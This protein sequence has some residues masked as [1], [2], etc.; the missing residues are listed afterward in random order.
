MN[1]FLPSL[2]NVERSK[3]WYS[4]LGG[5]IATAP[6]LSVSPLPGTALTWIGRV[7]ALLMEMGNISLATDFKFA[8]D[9][10]TGTSL[11]SPA[12]QSEKMRTA[13][14]LALGVAERLA[15]VL[16]RG[17]YIPVGSA[18]DALIAISGVLGKAS[19]DV[20]IIDP[21][22]SQVVLNDFALSLGEGVKL[23]LLS[24]HK[25]TAPDLEPALRA[26]RQQRTTRPTE[27]RIAKQEALHDRIIVLDG[28][29]WSLSQSFNALAKRSPATLQPF[30]PEL[31]SLKT[32]YY[33]DLWT[34]ATPL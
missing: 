6:D 20:F 26:W 1:L 4:E 27:V 30:E 8:F 15:P 7:H 11:D 34:G 16:S 19:T 25:K 3:H 33:E 17:A 23:R 13:M 24:G 21:Y 14:Y 12:S 29:A 32:A 2:Q 10:R 9:H 5:L 18:H 22:M 31:G 28:N